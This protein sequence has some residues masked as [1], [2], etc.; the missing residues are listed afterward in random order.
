MM[1]MTFCTHQSIWAFLILAPENVSTCFHCNKK[2]HMRTKYWFH[3]QNK[4]KGVKNDNKQGGQNSKF[5]FGNV[6]QLLDSP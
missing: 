2:G 1:A 3:P 5:A 4:N 6:W